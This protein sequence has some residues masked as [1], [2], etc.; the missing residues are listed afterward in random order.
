VIPFSGQHHLELIYLE[1][2]TGISSRTWRRFIA[3]GLIGVCRIGR[4]IRVPEAELER[5]LADHFHP[6]TSS[7]VPRTSRLPVRGSVTNIVDTVIE[8]NRKRDSRSTT[9]TERR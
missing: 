9:A 3:S 5:F 4:S 6:P 2:Q 7:K 1:K 8:R